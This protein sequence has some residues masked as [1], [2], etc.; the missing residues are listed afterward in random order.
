MKKI[1]LILTCLLILLTGCTA[2][3]HSGSTDNALNE[4][5]IGEG[6]MTVLRYLISSNA[7]LVEEVFIEKRL[8]AETGKDI[9]N[10][11]GVFAPVV[12]EKIKTYDELVQVIKSTYTAETADK[13]LS[14]FNYYKDIDGKLYL[15]TK[16]SVSQAENYDW[17]NP[18]IEVISVADGTYTLEV[19]VK[20]EN[21]FNHKLNIIAKDV[22]GNI[23]LENIYY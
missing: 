21:G 23:R 10:E 17:S 13:I 8:P 12:S 16:A 14:E 3:N 4:N 22:D 5:Y 1:I 2:K 6:Q 19:T 15:N 20:K 7:F 11:N 9:T 18:E